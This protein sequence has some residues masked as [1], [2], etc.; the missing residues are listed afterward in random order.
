MVVWDVSRDGEDSPSKASHRSPDF[1]PE[2]SFSCTIQFD[3]G[4]TAVMILHP[5][6]Y[7][8]KVLV[9]SGEGDLQLW[10]VRTQ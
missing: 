9:A 2:P 7:L 3:N 5:A 6:T 1:T 10:N 8:N 4:F